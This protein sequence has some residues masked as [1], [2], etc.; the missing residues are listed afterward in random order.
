MHSSLMS[1]G[2]GGLCCSE[3]SFQLC[4]SNQAQT[5][6]H[7]VSATAFASTFFSHLSPLKPS[8]QLQTTVGLPSLP[9]CPNP[10]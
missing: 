2:G 8:L 9:A 4:F 1:G 7:F 3:K 5:I 10:Q 6:L